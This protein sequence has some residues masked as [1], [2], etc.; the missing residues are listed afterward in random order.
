MKNFFTSMLVL[1]FM[2]TL[3]VTSASAFSLRAP[4]VAVAGGTLQGYLNSVGESINVNTDQQDASVWSTTISGNTTLT[5]MLEVAGFAGNNTYGLYNANDPSSTP[6]LFQVFPGAAGPGWFATAHFT[7][8]GGLVVSLFDDN[9]IFQGQSTYAGVNKNGFGFYIS[10][11]G[12]IFYSQDSRNG[13]TANV[14]TYAGTGANLGNWWQCFDDQAYGSGDHDFDD[15]V[16]FVESVNPA[17]TP[18]RA[19]TFGRIKSL[20]R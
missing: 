11:P 2:A 14:L 15:G 19:T 20:Y 13:G 10:G 9:A 1:T 7:S 8:T 16:I 18:T 17:P 3:L 6:T 12:G 4:Q 5:F